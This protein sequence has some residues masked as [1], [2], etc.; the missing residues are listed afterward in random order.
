LTIA[1][2]LAPG[3]LGDTALEQVLATS[4][5]EQLLRLDSEFAAYVPPERQRPRITLH[6]A[7]DP[8]YFPIGVKH[9]YSR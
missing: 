9:R 7:G 4:I 8:T 6:P 1:V 5:H 3:T 2:E